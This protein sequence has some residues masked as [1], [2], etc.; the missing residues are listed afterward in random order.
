MA[1]KTIE[2]DALA[3]LPFIQQS[4]CQG[5]KIYKKGLKTKVE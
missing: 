3:A 5:I 2:N 1:L 4:K